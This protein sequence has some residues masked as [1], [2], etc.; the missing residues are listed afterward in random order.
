M[1]YTILA[2]MVPGYPIRAH[3][4][5]NKARAIETAKALVDSGRYTHVCI[6]WYDESDG[7]DG[8]INP[9]GELT[10]MTNWVP[11]RDPLT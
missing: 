6:E 8:Y 2:G 11:E 9:E 3:L 10:T 7:T 1:T 4:I 5:R